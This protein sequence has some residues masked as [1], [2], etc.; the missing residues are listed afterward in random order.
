MEK[1]PG[2]KMKYHALNMKKIDNYKQKSL[3]QISRFRIRKVYRKAYFSEIYMEF[4]NKGKPPEDF[5][6]PKFIPEK[7]N[8]LMIDMYGN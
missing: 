4:E 5:K 8:W 6:Y 2:R 7:E 1:K 3:K